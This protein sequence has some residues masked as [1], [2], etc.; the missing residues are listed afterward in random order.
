[1]A[2]ILIDG[3]SKAYLTEGARGEFSALDK[4]SLSIATSESVSIVGPSGCGK[5]TLINLIAGFISPSQGSIRVGGQPVTGPGPDRAVVV[6]A[7]AVFPWMTVR[8]NLS[9]GPRVRGLPKSVWKPR[10]DHYLEVV[11]LADF[12]DSYPKALSGGMKKRVDLARAYVNDPEILLMDEPFGALDEFT[13]QVME[14]DLV[15]MI[16][17]EKKTVLFVTHDIEEAIFIG[18]RV[19]IMSPRPGRIIDIKS[20][21]FPQPRLPGIRTSAEFQSIRRGISGQLGIEV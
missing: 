15:R 11:G 5:T 21:P 9:Y 14:L 19:V 3:V 4:T 8:N 10:V 2:Q 12:A 18:D 6:Q 16:A 17:Q 20:I 7:D 13:K 1:M